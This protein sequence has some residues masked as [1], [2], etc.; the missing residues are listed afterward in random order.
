MFFKSSNSSE[1]LVGLREQISSKLGFG[2]G[3][4]LLMS[5]HNF[6]LHPYR[7]M[8]PFNDSHLNTRARKYQSVLR[9]NIS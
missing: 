5:A 1:T 7:G 3:I 4:E 9:K 2:W 6:L 8:T